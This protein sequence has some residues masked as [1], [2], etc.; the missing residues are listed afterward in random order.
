MLLRHKN[1]GNL[2]T[3]NNMDGPLGH[4]VREIRERQIL[5]DFSYIQSKKFILKSSY[6][7]RTG[8][9][10]MSEGGGLRLK[11]HTIGIFLICFT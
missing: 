10:E 7:Q 3:C 5:Y 1:E 9:G 11:K 4:Y 8:V 2:A 6:I